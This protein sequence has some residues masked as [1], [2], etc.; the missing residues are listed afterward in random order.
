LGVVLHHAVGVED[1]RELAHAALHAADP[2]A[3][4]IVHAAAVK[5]RQDLLLENVVERLALDLVLIIGV[6]VIL[7]AADRPA[8]VR[9]ITFDPPAVEHR[10]VEDAVGGG[11]HSAGAAGFV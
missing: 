6:G 3:R 2:F 5:E 1:R 11:L 7:A 10:A 8:D 4:N 9:R